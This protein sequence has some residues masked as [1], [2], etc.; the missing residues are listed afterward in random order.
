MI[1][2]VMSREDFSELVS[3][4]CN[5]D[6]F[7]HYIDDYKSQV[8]AEQSNK[9]LDSRFNAILKKYIP[10]AIDHDLMILVTGCDNLGRETC[11]AL[12]Q[13]LEASHK[14]KQWSITIAEDPREV[15][16]RKSYL[17][18]KNAKG[19]VMEAMEFVDDYRPELG[20]DERYA[21]RYS[22]W[23][24]RQFPRE[25]FASKKDG[26]DEYKRAMESEGFKK[27]TEADYLAFVEEVKLQIA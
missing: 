13:W 6:P 25:Y 20:K 16:V 2:A 1:S 12:K 23:P 27:G 3:V 9:S 22:L 15:G 24:A 18:R 21:D 17:I 10:E 7:T 19:Q 11:D 5:Y 14:Y 26:N 8:S 4:V